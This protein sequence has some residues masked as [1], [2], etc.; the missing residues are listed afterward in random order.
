M[1]FVD[2]VSEYPNRRKL[3]VVETTK[4]DDGNITEL[5]VD[6]AREEGTV[7]AE[8]TPLNANTLNP[9]LDNYLI[10]VEETAIESTV[11]SIPDTDVG[12]LNSFKTKGVTTGGS[13]SALV[14]VDDEFDVVSSN[15]NIL[16]MPDN[17]D[18]VTYSDGVDSCSIEVVDQVIIF[19]GDSLL[20]YATP[21]LNITTNGYE[22]L[23]HHYTLP[24]LTGKA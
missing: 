4:D 14:N 11:L 20:T 1:S 3:T 15:K 10:A 6:S 21:E 13:G 18:K 16:L 8:G 2:R 19:N 5:T 22:V 24:D 7:S 23:P 9:I 12:Y 17:M